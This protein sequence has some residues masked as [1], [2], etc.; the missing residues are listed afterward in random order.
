MIRTVATMMTSAVWHGIHSG[1]Y[2][3]LLTI[4]FI[5]IVE[6]MVWNVIREKLNAKVNFIHHLLKLFKKIVPDS[7]YL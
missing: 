3:S 6:D 4:P 1:Y 2:L 5:L 7:E